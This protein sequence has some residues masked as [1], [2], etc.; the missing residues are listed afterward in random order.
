MI[1]ELDT[2]LTLGLTAVHARV[3]VGIAQLDQEGKPAPR[4]SEIADWC[5][6][7]TAAATG[8]IDHME[9]NGHVTRSYSPHDRRS[10]FLSLTPKGKEIAGELL[11]EA[12]SSI[13]CEFCNEPPL[14]EKERKFMEENA[15]S[16]YGGK[17]SLT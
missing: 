10:I 14:T 6:V 11:K 13:P 2:V 9:R 17:E 15:E 12:L 8:M 3:I 5:K 1:A 16:S 7:S 4:M